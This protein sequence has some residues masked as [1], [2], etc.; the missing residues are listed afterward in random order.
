VATCIF[1]YK[2]AQT[3][4][5]LVNDTDE[6]IKKLNYFNNFIVIIEINFFIQL[7]FTFLKSFFIDTFVTVFFSFFLLFLKD[8]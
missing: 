1:I 5:F 2:L 6:A 3:F 8:F 4:Y 7:V